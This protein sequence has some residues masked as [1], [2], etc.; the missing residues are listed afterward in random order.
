MAVRILIADDNAHVRGALRA[1][2]EGAGPWEIFEAANGE[3]ALKLARERVFDLFLLDLAMPRMDGIRA[4]RAIASQYPNVP[5]LMHTLYSS[6]RIEIE[7]LKAGV[8]KVVPKSDAATIVAAVR[9]LLDSASVLSVNVAT[10]PDIAAMQPERSS[11]EA[12]N[13]ANGKDLAD[14]SEPGANVPED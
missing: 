6:R 9:E 5:I 11:P 1:V 14:C 4:A 2:L 10:V 7:A 13:D 3:E 8:R 12:R